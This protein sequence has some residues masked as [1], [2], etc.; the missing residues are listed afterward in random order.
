MGAEGCALQGQKYS[1]VAGNARG[2]SVLEP[3]IRTVIDLGSQFTRVL[4]TRGGQVEDFVMSEKCATGSGRFLQI[5]ARIL[6]MPI[7]EM[8]PLSLAAHHPVDFSTSCAVF[9]ESEAISRLAEGTSPADIL[10]GVHRAMASKV[11]MLVGRLKWHPPVALVGGGGNDVGLVKAI[12]D[13]LETT[14]HVPPFPQTV[15]ALGV[16]WLAAVDC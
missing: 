12:E 3:T 10:A 4:T 11:V 2:I 9:A 14:I 15:A 1:D 5:M 16:A 6:Q 8:G 13:A 7:T